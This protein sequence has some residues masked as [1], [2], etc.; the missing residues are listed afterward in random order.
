ML[1]LSSIRGRQKT[2]EVHGQV[3]V[4]WRQ[5]RRDF[6]PLLDPEGARA[7]LDERGV[8]GL[9]AKAS[10]T[11]IRQAGGTAACTPHPLEDLGVWDSLDETET[12]KR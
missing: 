4:R 10:K 8:R 7:E 1:L 11:A 12:E 9:P 3:A 2:D 6:D 5:L